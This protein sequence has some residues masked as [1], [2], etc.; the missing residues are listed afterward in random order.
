MSE[1]QKSEHFLKNWKSELKKLGEYEF[2]NVLNEMLIVADPKNYN[3][4]KEVILDIYINLA[5]NVLMRIPSIQDVFQGVIDLNF[6]IF[7]IYSEYECISGDKAEEF[8]NKVLSDVKDFIDYERSYSAY[9][10]SEVLTF[11][12]VKIRKNSEETIMHDMAI[13]LLNRFNTDKTDLLFNIIKQVLDEEQHCY[14][15]GNNCVLNTL[16]K[17]DDVKIY[18]NH[19]QQLV[20]PDIHFEHVKRASRYPSLCPDY[21]I[22][23]FMEA[24]FI[25][26]VEIIRTG[27]GYVKNEFR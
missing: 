12:I 15:A 16:I 27:G 24:R 19:S 17:D 18:F 25:K 5:T 9:E 2:K 10:E 8:E 13:A 4:D 23:D 11:D 22:D 20:N 26:D 21:T 3:R 14:L 7:N 1:L 6:S